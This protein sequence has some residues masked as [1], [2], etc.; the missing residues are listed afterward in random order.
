MSDAING[1]QTTL[2]YAGNN[3]AV[4]TVTTIAEIIS[5]TLPKLEVNDIDVTNMD[6]ASNFMEFIP[7]STNPGVI[8]LTVNY[9]EAQDE[10]LSDRVGGTNPSEIWEI[11]FP[12]SATW[13]V[14]GYINGFGAGEASNN[15]KISR[16]LSIKCVGLPTH[17]TNAPA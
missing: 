4:T 14:K 5:L 1:F 15:D 11:T 10:I 7:G 13:A 12:D 16:E 8:D 9:T 17:T 6:S 2:S 3:T